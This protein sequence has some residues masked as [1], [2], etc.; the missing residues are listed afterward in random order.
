MFSEEISYLKS[1]KLARMPPYRL[2]A[3]RTIHINNCHGLKA[4]LAPSS[5]GRRFAEDCSNLF[6]DVRRDAR[7]R[8][9]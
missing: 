7:L 8:T 6:L 2:R 5:K 4:T 9:Q 1:Q 3:S